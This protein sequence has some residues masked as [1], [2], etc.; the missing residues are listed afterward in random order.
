MTSI[1]ESIRRLFTP[2]KPLQ[3][4]TYHFQAS[5][6]AP[7][8]YRLHLRLE[9]D[10]NGIL[11][12]NA[13]TVLHLNQT[14]AEYAYH[15]VQNTS[16]EDMVKQISRRYRVSNQQALADYRDLVDRIQTLITT[17]DLDPETFL[18]FERS[19]PYDKGMTAPYRLDCALTY[20]L[21]PGTDPATAPIKR[22]DR[23]LTSD[24]WRQ[25]IDQAWNAGIPHIIF[26]GGEPTLRDDLAIL[27]AHAEANGQ[28]TGLLS[29]GLRFVD[30][31][32]LE[33]L[34]ATGLDHMLIV[35][36]PEERNAWVALENSLAADIYVAIHLTITTDN[37]AMA[38]DLIKRL[39][40]MGVK[41]ISLSAADP[42]LFTA[43]S[44]LRDQAAE[45]DLTLIW[46]LPV[47]YSASNP[48]T[49][50]TQEDATLQGAGR[51]WLY[52]EPD[53]DVLPAQGVN[54]VLGN[55]LNDPW[56]KIWHSITSSPID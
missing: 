10:G 51:A 25:I 46:D 44:D 1:R 47:P 27:I 43:L 13:A 16:E 12:V 19:I 22:V 53:G 50:E 38:Q 56:E 54:R 42:T 29:D 31:K 34:L 17:P 40:E 11:I 14:A 49:L 3:V 35:F 37:A 5:P 8:P 33:A 9:T 18:D 6:D 45:L 4:G 7:L 20:Q 39:A 15:I 55:F 21:P 52:V 36:Q 30:T 41:A 24:E 32:Y 48:V 23:E 28:V 2:A 26:T